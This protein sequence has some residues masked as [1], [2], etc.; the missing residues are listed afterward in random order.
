MSDSV[1]PAVSARRFY[2]MD[3]VKQLG[4]IA[5]GLVTSLGSLVDG[6]KGSTAT[7]EGISHKIS[8]TNTSY[9]MQ[10]KEFSTELKLLDNYYTKVYI[11]TKAMVEFGINAIPNI[12]TLITEKREYDAA[13]KEIKSFLDILADRIK[14]ILDELADHDEK[15]AVSKEL[16]QIQKLNKRYEIS[17]EHLQSLAENQKTAECFKIGKNILL[18]S[19]VATDGVWLC[20][21]SSVNEKFERAC[22]YIA[23]NPDVLP[24]IT[25]K[26]I[27][28]FNAITKSLGDT[29][30]LKAT[31]EEQAQ[32]MS[33]RFYEFFE[34]IT[35]FQ[36]Q[37]HTIVNNTEELKKCTEELQC[38]LKDDSEKT[39]TEWINIAF[40][41]QEMYELFENLDKEVVQKK[42][43]WETHEM[44]SPV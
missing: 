20:G 37:I 29:D 9:A 8:Q 41:L 16:Q 10:L 44:E 12:K 30:S 38:Q 18:L 35:E 31:I 7:I 40:K 17:K 33:K 3:I 43:Y 6:L 34:K 1:T 42:I 26:G 27:Q 15:V 14:K 13:I 5:S 4:Y 19:S 32:N 24:F 22:T 21:N 23:D 2:I 11:K 36:I 39:T 25:D 28:G